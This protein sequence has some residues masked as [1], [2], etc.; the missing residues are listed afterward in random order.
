MAEGVDDTPPST[1]AGGAF[2]VIRTQS[3]PRN[4]LKVDFSLITP[5]AGAIT[6]LPLVAV[7]AIGLTVTSASGAIA[8][9]IGANLIAV[10]SL[11][12]APRLS[13]R[14]A[15]V[16]VLMMGVSVFVGTLTSPV[17]WLHIVVLAPWC[18][19]AG[20]MVVFGQTQAT[21]GTQ[22]IIAYVVLGRFAGTPSVALHLCFFVMVGALT[23][24]LALVVLRLPPTLRYQRG[25]L[26]NAFEAVSELARS[27][28]NRPATDILGSLDDA[29]FALSSPSLFSRSDVQDLR[30]ILDQARRIRLEL[31]T[32]AGLRVR[33]AREAGSAGSSL[34]DTALERAA[35]A[36][37]AIAGALRRTSIPSQWKGAV[38]DYRTSLQ[39]LGDGFDDK[40]ST[41][42]V[43]ARQCVSHLIAIGGQLRSAGNLVDHLQ[44][45]DNRQAWRPSIPAPRGPDFGQFRIDISTVRGNLRSDS[46]AL[47]HAVRL[48][49]AVPAS[50]LIGSLLSLPRGYWLPFAV[51]VILKPDYSTLVK[52]G[53]GRVIGT[54]IGATVAAVLVSELKPDLALTAVL[55]AIIGWIAYSSWAASFSVAIGFITAMVLILLSTSTTDTLGT[56]VDRLI[57]IS[58]GGAIAVITYLV[59]PTSPRAGVGRAQSSLFLALRDYLRVVVDLVESKPVNADEIARCSRK[60]RMAWAGAEA[61]V[62]R[63]VEEPASTRIDPSEGRSLLATTLRILRAVHAL[64]IE[65]ERGAT[66]EPFAELESLASA[67]LDSLDGLGNWFGAGVHAE[68]P[69]LRP[70]YGAAE[71]ALVRLGAAASIAT[72]LDELVNAINTATHLSGMPA[73]SPLG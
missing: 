59:W 12:G 47:R 68:A 57:D 52:R 27:N 31:T 45:V 46:P 48:A 64:R 29:E 7:F 72:H 49:V 21:V 26:A 3:A 11:V 41:L 9:A 67:C 70:L 20:M 62:G 13:I 22:A 56:A 10:V 15:L 5:V 2:S 60:V 71:K 19:V 51:A 6:V 42:D 50:I 8:L 44:Q 28:P 35:E 33:L 39:L 18:F 58:L 53:L 63:S 34:I 4:S 69:A 66:V 61:A 54:M 37:D 25:R 55:V 1:P 30:S 14:L 16:D 24:V 73:P 17:A 32:L 40:G 43:I 23:E 36:L 38:D 65:A